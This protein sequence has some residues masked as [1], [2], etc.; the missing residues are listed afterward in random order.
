MGAKLVPPPM[1]Q[2]P[3]RGRSALCKLFLQAEHPLWVEATVVTPGQGLCLLDLV[4]TTQFFPWQP[5]TPGTVF[6]GD[7]L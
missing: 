4:Q 1:E 5:S 2:L 3:S 6:K 7:Q